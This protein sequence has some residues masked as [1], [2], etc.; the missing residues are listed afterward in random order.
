METSWLPRWMARSIGGVEPPLFRPPIIASP[1]GLLWISEFL[2]SQSL[3]P[4]PYHRN[5]VSKRMVVKLI[6][7]NYCRRDDRVRHIFL[8]HEADTIVLIPLNPTWP[9]DKLVW[10]FTLTG[11]YT[12]KSAYQIGMVFSEIGYY[13]KYF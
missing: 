7:H 11:I 12:V 9:E 6:D 8:Q 13:S 3:S 1:L 5:K 2:L 10:S 4:S